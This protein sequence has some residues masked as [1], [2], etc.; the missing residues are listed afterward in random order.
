[1]GDNTAYIERCE[2]Q[3]TG[4]WTTCK[5][6][7]AF[8]DPNCTQ[9]QDLVIYSM[10]AVTDKDV[11]TAGTSVDENGQPAFT[12]LYYD[13]NNKDSC[14]GFTGFNGAFYGDSWR[15]MVVPSDGSGV[16]YAIRGTS[17]D[18]LWAAGSDGKVF[19]TS[20]AFG[21]WH[22]L[23]PRS[24]G[25]DW[26]ES[27]TSYGLLVEQDQVHIVGTRYDQLPFYLH[28]TR[29]DDKV[30]PWRFDYIRYFSEWGW[31]GQS[32]L[33]SIARDRWNHVLKAVGYYYDQWAG[34]TYGLIMTLEGSGE[35]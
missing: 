12:V 6:M 13:G 11:W 29:V 18:N 3:E 17:W 30:N 26:D 25:F 4:E 24:F 34:M 31:S 28:A 21:G 15:A 14:N 7:A 23:S 1:M 35:D 33:R 5:P 16:L 19:T 20:G 2:R 8:I 22:E 27:N 9:M 10:V 32:A